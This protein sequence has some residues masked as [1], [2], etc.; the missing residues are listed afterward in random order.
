MVNL[1]LSKYGFPKDFEVTEEGRGLSVVGCWL[2]VVGC[3]L[4]V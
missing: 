3:R 4:S 2:S 1:Q